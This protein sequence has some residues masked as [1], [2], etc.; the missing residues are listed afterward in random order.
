[1]RR[2]LTHLDAHKRVDGQ[3]HVLSQLKR[4]RGLRFE[5]SGKAP[6]FA[7]RCGMEEVACVRVSAA[8]QVQRYH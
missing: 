3:R 2:A 4:L 1:M 8:L 6:D 7:G 5:V